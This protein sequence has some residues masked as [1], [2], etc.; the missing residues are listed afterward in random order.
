MK[1]NKKKED[2]IVVKLCAEL[3]KKFKRNKKLLKFPIELDCFVNVFKDVTVYSYNN[4]KNWKMIFGDAE[5]DIVF[6]VSPEHSHLKI[7]FDNKYITRARNSFPIK[8]KAKNRKHFEYCVVPYIIWEVKYGS[9]NSHNISLYSNYAEQ[10]KDKFPHV[11]YNFVT[12][13]SSKTPETLARQGKNF[14][15]IISEKSSIKEAAKKM[16]KISRERLNHYGVLK[17]K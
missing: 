17:D 1:S 16:Y 10:I 4:S 2:E 12:I 5:Q 14:D 6:Y 7:P 8:S 3:K 9:L 15:F 13:G 11:M